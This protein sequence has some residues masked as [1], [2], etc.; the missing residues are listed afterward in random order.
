[1]CKRLINACVGCCDVTPDR[2]ITCK[3]YRPDDRVAIGTWLHR[4]AKS[5]GRVINTVKFR[6]CLICKTKAKYLDQP[7]CD[8]FYGKVM[9]KMVNQM[10]AYMVG[11]VEVRV[12][13]VS[14]GKTSCV[15]FTD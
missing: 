4:H 9:I 15:V 7:E 13:F 8:R 14:E 6:F 5:G 2:V 1:M 11:E 12:K 3:S 10:K